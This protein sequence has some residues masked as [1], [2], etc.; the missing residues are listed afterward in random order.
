MNCSTAWK[1]FNENY[2]DKGDFFT[3]PRSLWKV[4]SLFE[5][6]TFDKKQ[7]RKY[8]GNKWPA[9][10]VKTYSS[11]CPSDFEDGAMNVP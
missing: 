3:A 4:K 5:P 11:P 7:L 8:S 10:S 9:N 2:V 1:L 6:K